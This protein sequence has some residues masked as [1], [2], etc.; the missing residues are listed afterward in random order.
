M[1]E[2]GTASASHASRTSRHGVW[3]PSGGP[4]WPAIRT[5]IRGL[6]AVGATLLTVLLV[7]LSL[8]TVPVPALSVF[9]ALVG[10]EG[11]V[12]T[13][14]VAGFR[15]PRAL[16]A[17]MAGAAISVAGLLLQ[18]LLRNPLAGPWMLG[19]IGSARLGVAVLLTLGPI[20][21]LRLATTLGPLASSALI[22]AAVAGAAVGM[23]A[24]AWIAR[25]VTPVTLLIT[26]VIVTY[27][28]DSAASFLIILAPPSQK[29]IFTAWNDGTFDAIT[30][31][32][33]RI[34]IV[35]A[36]AALVASAG[37]FKVLDALPLGDRYASSM[38][39]HVARTRR[40]TIAI[41]V[42]LS[43]SVTAFCG[44]LTFLDVAVPHLARGV[45]RTASHTTL[46]PATALLGALLALVADLATSLPG[47][48]QVLH[49]NYTTAIVGG[50]VILWVLLRRRQV[51]F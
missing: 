10:M 19:V 43:G 1:S 20:V 28:M 34:L 27:V 5:P 32:Q 41:V 12:P 49:V 44:P 4:A 25:R 39:H 42:V 33:L 50:P 13:S 35:V 51:S 47:A 16:T 30:W 18:T 23:T 7:R 17:M 46:I 36:L 21:G 3:R 2:S 38:G 6:V 22:V 24:V 14:I 40:L 11:P 8:G 37:L 26:G 9:A 29:S 15:L 45:F 31:P 48:Q